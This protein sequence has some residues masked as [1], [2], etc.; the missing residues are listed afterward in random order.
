MSEGL[1][2]FTNCPEV[3]QRELTNCF[4]ALVFEMIYSLFVP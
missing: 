3:K 1:S 2:V 4:H